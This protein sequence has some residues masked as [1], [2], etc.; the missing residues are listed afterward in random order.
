MCANVRKGLI[1]IYKIII[2]VIA[3]ALVAL[4][5]APSL[6]QDVIPDEEEVIG[7][8]G[9]VTPS[10]PLLVTTQGATSI[11]G[12]SANLNGYL[13]SMGP[14]S[15]VDVWFETEDGAEISHQSMSSPGFFT[16]YLGQL[17]SGTSYRYRAVAAAPLL[18]G[19]VSRGSFVSFT[20]QHTVPQAPIEVSTSSASDITTGSA[21]LRGYLTSMGPYDSISVWFQWGSSTGYGNTTVQQTVYGPGP[22]SIQI[23]GLKANSM[24]YFRAAAK[25]DLL[26]VS[27]VYGNSQSFST[28]GAA[29][30]A[31]NTGSVSSVT[32][33]SATLVGYLESLGEYRNA[34][35]WF[36][37]GPTTTYGQTT[38]MQTMY[39][40]GTFNFT[41]QGLN[42]GTIYHYRALAVPTAAG[43]MTVHGFDSMFTTTAAPGVK[44]STGTA[45]SITA[46][47]AVLNGYLTALGMSSTAYV[48]FEYGTDTTFGHSTPHQSLSIPGSFNSS[49]ANLQPGLTYYYRAAAFSN[50]YNVYGQYSTFQ[51]TPSSPVSL[52]TGTATG[53]STTG[54]TLNAYVNSLGGLRSIQ[55]YFNFG[56][57]MG[58]GNVTAAQTVTSPGAVSYQVMGLTP[59]TTY[60]F[61]SVA[62]TPE[63]LKVY[64]PTEIFSTISNSS[65]SVATYPVTSVTSSSAILN[66]YLQDI[67][68][69][70][71]AQVWF[72]YGTTADLGNTTNMQMLNNSGSFSSVVTGLA[73]GRT[74]YYRA[75]ALNPTGGGRSVNGS[76]SSFVTPGGGPAPVPGVPVFVWLIIGGFVIVIIIVIILLA[77]RR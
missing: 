45:S 18:G 28:P 63:N 44:V 39:S 24:Y 66:G 48:W 60:Y 62:Q 31:V 42:P 72:E 38:T 59:G 1:M 49:V 25:P 34:Y 70:S 3:L 41:I 40:P 50:G 74:Y 57:T 17:E 46:Q 56:K 23:S 77:S 22:F 54:A 21:V 10:Q 19:Q 64:G 5:A 37:W 61:Q 20:T 36:E 52:T 53:I 11:T 15:V 29:G 58:F 68:N 8:G 76:I 73:Q 33:S 14:Y 7:G 2:S 65:L 12:T 6:A 55:V 47:S 51:T 27:A 30:L 26:G 43:G 9:V 16:G 32:S 75:V 35:V 71:S 13:Q 69:T 67:G 4:I